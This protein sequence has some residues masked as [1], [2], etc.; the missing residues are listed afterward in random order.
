MQQFWSNNASF[1][2]FY[3]VAF[4]HVHSHLNTNHLHRFLLSLFRHFSKTNINKTSLLTLIHLYIHFILVNFVTGSSF[5]HNLVTFYLCQN[6]V[7]TS[8][9]HDSLSPSFTFEDHWFVCWM[10]QQKSYKCFRLFVLQTTQTFQ[11]YN[12]KVLVPIKLQG[13]IINTRAL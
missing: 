12:N 5:V 1:N 7:P 11:D 10:K 13:K 3:F 4:P 9:S 8:A 2:P 6:W